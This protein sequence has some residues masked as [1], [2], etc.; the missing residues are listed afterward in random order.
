MGKIQTSQ[1][2][3]WV[4]EG[5]AIVIGPDLGKT[6]EGNQ[7]SLAVPIFVL[8]GFFPPIP[9]TCSSAFV[10]DQQSPEFQAYHLISPYVSNPQVNVK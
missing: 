9:L 2:S 1:P 7:L 5:Y 10:Q 6:D 8:H 3:R 4:V